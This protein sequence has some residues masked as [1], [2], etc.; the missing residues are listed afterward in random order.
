MGNLMGK[1]VPGRE[2]RRGEIERANLFRLRPALLHGLEVGNET[3]LVAAKLLRVEVARLLRNIDDGS[4]ILKLTQYGF[5]LGF[6]HVHI[7]F[8]ACGRAVY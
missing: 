4:E 3:P 6:T 7:S 8:G 1:L 2:F 5:T